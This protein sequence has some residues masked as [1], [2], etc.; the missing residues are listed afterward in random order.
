MRS[1]SPF[2]RIVSGSG[3]ISK[4]IQICITRAMAATAARGLQSRGACGGSAARRLVSD[5][6]R[7]IAAAE[8]TAVQKVGLP[9]ARA[10][11]I[12]T[13]GTEA[14][15]KTLPRMTSRTGE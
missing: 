10:S 3:K 12:E 8:H 9:V 4:L 14:R 1:G 13:T 7:V 15:E 5:A 11:G 6:I 2:H